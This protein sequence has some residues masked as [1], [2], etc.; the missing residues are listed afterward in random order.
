M[1]PLWLGFYVLI[2]LFAAAI[3]ARIARAIWRHGH[4]PGRGER[5]WS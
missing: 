3:V 2:A 5:P 1:T 4:A